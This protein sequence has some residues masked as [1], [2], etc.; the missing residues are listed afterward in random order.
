MAREIIPA[1]TKKRRA[2]KSFFKLAN[3]LLGRLNL[4]GDLHTL[5]TPALIR[6]SLQGNGIHDDLGH[7]PAPIQTISGMTYEFLDGVK[8]SC[9]TV[10]HVAHALEASIDVLG[11]IFH[12]PEVLALSYVYDP[13]ALEIDAARVKSPT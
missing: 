13:Y 4:P 1:D 2:N 3:T 7:P 12:T 6:N 10:A 11:R 9:A 5:N 8:V